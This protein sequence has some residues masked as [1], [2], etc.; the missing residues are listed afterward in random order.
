V[1]VE[2]I[3]ALYEEMV[4]ETDIPRY[5]YFGRE[6]V[7]TLLLEVYCRKQEVAT[8]AARLESMDRE[9]DH[10]LRAYESLA[11]ECS[12]LREEL[13]ASERRRD[14]EMCRADCLA[15]LLENGSEEMRRLQAME[16]RVKEGHLTEEEFQAICHNLC[17]DDEERFK[18]GC[19]QTWEKLFHSAVRL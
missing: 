4:Y 18:A 9:T 10:M 19:R 3:A 11:S 12:R 6:I 15:Q 17:P 7:L 13:K 2:E 16:Q 5:G 14:E 1:T 8:L